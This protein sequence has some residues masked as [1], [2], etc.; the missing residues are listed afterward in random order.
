M[1]DKVGYI[2]VTPTDASCY[3]I[4]DL[5]EKSC[6]QNC[7]PIF[8]FHCT[9]MYDRSNPRIKKDFQ[10]S[11]ENKF[12]SKS[13]YY[14]GY[15]TGVDILGEIG[16]PW[17]AI[18]LTLESNDLH[19]RHKQLLDL[20][21]NHSYSEFKPHISIKYQPNESDNIERLKEI[22]EFFKPIIVTFDKENWRLVK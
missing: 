13:C 3:R 19:I 18:V 9:L 8:D 15:I 5:I 16:S 1:E 6:I 21:F 12:N 11:E 10:Q 22:I 17:R 4:Q 20:G 14:V 2:N 7:I